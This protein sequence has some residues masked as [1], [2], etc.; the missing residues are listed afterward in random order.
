[1]A[2]VTVEGERARRWS[3]L[4][5]S[6]HETPVNEYSSFSRKLPAVFTGLGGALAILGALGKWTRATRGT[7]SQRAAEEVQAVM[8]HS[9]LIGW[10]I[11]AVGLLALVGSV[12]WFMK[13]FFPKLVPIGAALV[14]AG[15]G[16]W[17]LLELQ[18]RYRAMAQAARKAALDSTTSYVFHAGY[19]WGA[20]LLL[21]G[22]ILLVLGAIAGLL[23]QLDVR[24]GIAE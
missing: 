15:A 11:A 21:A 1:M 19:G 14:V 4:V 5:G 9:S 7:A 10:A 17:Q 12:A 2:D 22:A 8:G 20:W 13:R 3:E 6:L 16:V 23:R 24:R 18:D